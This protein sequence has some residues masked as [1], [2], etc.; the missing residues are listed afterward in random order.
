LA[1]HAIQ[2]VPLTRGQRWLFAAAL[3]ALAVSASWTGVFNEFTYD[4]RFIVQSNVAM[5]DLRNWWR[6]FGM[7]YWPAQWGSDGYRP[8]TI[9]AYSIEWAAGHG[10]PWIFH[11]VNIGLYAVVSVAV[12]YLAETVLPF[13]A[14][15][16]AA[17]LFAVHP[18]HVEAVAN[19][20]G[21]SELLV[22]MF[23]IPAVTIYVRRR[24]ANE[25]TAGP[26]VAIA[27]LYA[28]ACLAK[29]HGFVLPVVL[30]AAELVVVQ[31]KTP[32]R[33]R[34]AT[35]RPFALSLALISAAYLWVHAQ[36]N[37]DL[38]GFHPYVPFGGVGSGV[39]GRAFTMF[40]LV[41]EWFR[42]FLWPNHLSAEYGP[43]AFPVVN[44]FQWYQ[45]P[46]LLAL[47]GVLALGV[48][49]WRKAPAVSFGI[50]FLVI[51]LLPTSNFIVPSGILL[52]E[53]TL[54]MPSVGVMIA[55]AAVVPWLYVH[56]RSRPWRIV[57]VAALPALLALGAWRSDERT[58]VWKDNETLFATT[59]VDAPFVYRSH[60]MLGAWKLSLKRKVEGEREYRLAMAMYDKDPFVYYSLGE[61]Y[62]LF[63]MFK[64][65]I[66][67]FRRALQVDTT[68]IEARARIA[69]SLASLGR[70]PEANSEAIMA[71][72]QNTLSTTAMLRIIR[73]A[74]A[75][76]KRSTAASSADSG[77]VGTAPSPPRDSGKVPATVQ[78]PSSPAATAPVA[79]T[80]PP[81]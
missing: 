15:W 14:A 7:P 60:F 67:M 19:V 52:A 61:D 75:E 27:L 22:A 11:A 5:H 43:P 80:K 9:L 73:R 53:R 8:V 34:L 32:L 64:P 55:V 12:F 54:F 41:P 51:T 74:A 36:I 45:A 16:V 63:G 44:E 42:L 25:M 81:I 59:V 72:R 29:E 3:I 20:V 31:D 46:G 37:H 35:L 28:A 65:A 69:L 47:A 30:V 39:T 68:M 21:Q 40:G 24:N 48:A 71:L 38:A 1:H 18:L 13:A 77:R 33:A 70:W 58:G 56:A 49:T 57:A 78:N 10:K 79:K 66:V 26:M 50:W 76:A 2:P 23:M 6:F 17:A 62:R 4:D